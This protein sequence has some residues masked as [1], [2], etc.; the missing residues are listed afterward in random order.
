MLTCTCTCSL[1]AACCVLCAALPSL[2]TAQM[3]GPASDRG[4]NYRAL[5]LLFAAAPAQTDTRYEF[6]VSLLE[7]YNEKIVD[8][9]A[10]AD[11]SGANASGLKVK[12]GENG[13]EVAGLVVVPV[14]SAEQVVKLMKKGMSYRSVAA[15]DSNAN[16][17]RSHLYVGGTRRGAGL[18]CAGLCSVV[19]A[20]T[21]HLSVW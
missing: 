12:K 18:C 20:V 16:S 2:C 11:G 14:A 4:V 3:E 15:T 17:S 6:H 8:L 1:P 19:C 21:N 9:L 7:I 5:D 13:V 10:S